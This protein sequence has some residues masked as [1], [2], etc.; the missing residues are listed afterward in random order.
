MED[1]KKVKDAFLK[2]YNRGDIICSGHCYKGGDRFAEVIAKE[3][4]C[5][6]M[7]FP[8]DWKRYGKAAG[9][10]RNTDIA[11][12]S[13]KLIACVAHDRKGGTEDTIKKF[14]QAHGEE[15]LII[16]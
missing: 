4:N 16:V 15:N 1:F 2:I 3:F 12:R 11:L 9:F 5:P 8:A 14:I 10:I 13:N 6:T 7:I